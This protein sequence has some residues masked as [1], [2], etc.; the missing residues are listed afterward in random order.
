M[1]ACLGKYV[2]LVILSYYRQQPPPKYNP[3]IVGLDH[4][5]VQRILGRGGF[6]RVNAVI[7]LS[8]PYQGQ[9]FA[10]KTIHKQ[11]LITSKKADKARANVFAE[12]N[13][14]AVVKHPFI[15]NSYCIFYLYNFI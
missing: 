4:F 9:W 10:L 13:I 12:R 2:I 7:K 1:G 5:E 6:G 3:D 15:C 11:L 8:P 14:L